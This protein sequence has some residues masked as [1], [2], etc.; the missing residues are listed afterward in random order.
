MILRFLKSYEVIHKKTGERLALKLPII[1][2]EK[3]GVKMLID[4]AKIYKKL[5]NPSQG[6]ANVKMIKYTDNF[7]DILKS[8]KGDNHSSHDNKTHLIDTRIIVMDLLGPS[9]EDLFEMNNKKFSLQTVIKLAINFIDIIQYIHS[10]GYI[11]RDLKP[12]N[13]TIGYIDKD[14][15]FCIDF[16]LAKKY[17]NKSGNHITFMK[18]RGFCGTAVY[19]SIAAHAYHEQS[20]KDDLES[21]AYMLIYLYKGKLPW[22][23]IK[24][25]DKKTKYKMIYQEKLKCSPEELCKGMPRQFCVFLDYV[26]TMDF[27]EKPPYNSFKKMFMR[28]YDTMEYP[29][30]LFDWERKKC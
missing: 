15:L 18:K 28:L 1:S 13:F 30:S 12:D 14:K 2:K 6:I 3:N 4:E 7:T 27:D 24:A 29:D 19:A 16:G 26:R 17:L 5:S 8:K 10:N 11:H 22:K 9:L 25:K 20:R 21:I 23:S